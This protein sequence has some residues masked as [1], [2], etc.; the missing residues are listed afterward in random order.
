MI[1]DPAGFF[2][3]YP[4][5][6]RRRLIVEHYANA[7]VLDCVLEGSTPTALYATAVERGL[8]TRL[9][10]AAYLGRE[11]ARAHRAMETGEPYVQ[12]RAPGE[13]EEP[14]SAVATCGCETECAPERVD[15]Q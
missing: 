5:A 6:P 7:C 10:H 11:L 1:P 14:E 8:V 4:D 15:E 12:D 3:L 9:D 13:V 2:V